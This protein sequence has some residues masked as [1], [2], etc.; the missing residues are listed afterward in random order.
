[1]QI[2][3][4]HSLQQINENSTNFLRFDFLE[5]DKRDKDKTQV[6]TIS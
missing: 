3:C 4:E 5:K 6:R 2:G 1:M